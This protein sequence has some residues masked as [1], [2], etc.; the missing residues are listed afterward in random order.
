M[1]TYQKLF[2]VTVIET[3]F[4]NWFVLGDPS[5][6]NAAAAKVLQPSGEFDHCRFV[7]TDAEGKNNATYYI[8]GNSYDYDVIFSPEAHHWFA[9]GAVRTLTAANFTP[10]D[11]ITIETRW[12]PAGPD[13]MHNIH[14]RAFSHGVWILLT[15]SAGSSYFFDWEQFRTLMKP[16]RG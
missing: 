2:T 4:G 1:S 11:T 12:V 6:D 3:L 10:G 15:Q 16:S 14:L 9:K 7:V 13:S 8:A 5:A